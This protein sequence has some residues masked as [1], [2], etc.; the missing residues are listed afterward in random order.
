MPKRGENIHKRKDGRWEARYRTGVDPSGKITYGSVYAK[1]Y[2]EAREKQQERMNAVT[3]KLPINQKNL[4]F[5]EVADLWMENN[6][7]RLKGST[8]YRYRNLLESH[9][10]P[11][12]GGRRIDLITGTEINTYLADKLQ[13]GRID[14]KGGLSP[15]YVRSIMLI[16]NSV[17]TYAIEH[18]MRPPLQTKIY[19]PQAVKQDLPILT[20]QEQS[21]LV[22]QCRSHL[23]PTSIGV[24]LSLYAGLR[25][26]E[27][28]ALE[29][30]D[31]D[32]SAQIIYVR[33]T[34]ARVR[35]PGGGSHSM[36]VIE[37]PKTS[38]SYR[39]V[40]LCSWLI[41]LLNEV[42][43]HSISKFVV[44][45]TLQFVSPRTFDYRYHRLLSS[46]EIPSVNY[47]ALRHTFA[48]R[49]IEAGTDVKSLSEMLGH[50][51]AA[52]TLNIYVHPSM[53][54]KRAQLE[55]LSL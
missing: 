16:I 38:S 12:I 36:L 35:I 49:C 5:V 34:V 37:T 52:V 19:K 23:D 6:R 13:S 20:P 33:K 30:T 27:I 11:D 9:I 25:I 18:Q 7:L 43:S 4:L 3:R 14:N 22:S 8:D 17:L 45:T 28:C 21:K 24:L 15:S 39:E 54:T 44:S 51:N 55:K 26:G 1:T 32:L 53:E 31:I 29:W 48:T 41:P 2:R 40:P 50:A 47:H 46:A 42:R 10:I